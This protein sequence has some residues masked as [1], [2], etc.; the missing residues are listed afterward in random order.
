VID[1]WVFIK[2]KIVVWGAMSLF[3]L[4]AI[5]IAEKL[6]LF[7]FGVANLIKSDFSDFSLLIPGSIISPDIY[8]YGSAAGLWLSSFGIQVG[9]WFA[10]I[11]F[12]TWFS[13]KIDDY[14]FS[15]KI[16][17]MLNWFTIKLLLDRPTFILLTVIPIFSYIVIVG[18]ENVTLLGLLISEIPKIF[19]IGYAILAIIGSLFDGNTVVK[20]L[21]GVGLASLCALSFFPYFQEIHMLTNGFLTSGSLL[22]GVISLFMP[23]E[24]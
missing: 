12:I 22:F 23:E 9:L 16:V 2:G 13:Y 7:L 17:S 20:M 4:G 11:R 15:I 18:I 3:F 14:A 24:A 10:M 6:L 21:A 5:W 8:L 19:L 1:G